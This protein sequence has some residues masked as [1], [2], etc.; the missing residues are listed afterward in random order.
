MTKSHTQRCASLVRYLAGTVGLALM[1]VSVL[2]AE[3][4]RFNLPA[5]DAAQSVKELARQSGL[6]V[7]APNADLRGVGTN[8]VDGDYEPMEALRLMLHGTGLDI[9]QTDADTVT[10]VRPR[11]GQIVAQASQA[12]ARPEETGPAVEATE[13][14]GDANVAQALPERLEEIVVTGSR[15]RRSG[16][17]TLESAIVTDAEQIGRRAYTNVIQALDDTPGF[18]SSGVNPIGTDQGTL[19][20]GQSFADFFGLGSQR[21]LTLVNSRRFVSSNS[22]SSTGNSASPG[23]QVDLNLIPVGLVERIETVAIGG[24]P[25]YGSD[26][27]SGTVNVILKDDFEGLQT[28]AQYGI[29]EQGDGEGYTIRALAGWNFAE[30]RGNFAI[31]A[32][33]NEQKGLVLSKR[34][35][36]RFTLPNLTGSPSANLVTEDLTL[37][38]MT[39]GGLPLNPMTFGNIVDGSGTPLQF[40]ADGQL[41][42][43]IT[44]DPLNGLIAA[45]FTDGGDGVRFADHRSLLSPTERSLVNAIGHFDL[46]SSVRI[47]GEAAYAN[48][49]GKELS[50][51][52][53]FAAPLLSGTAI[54]VSI[55]N[56][57]LS[58][59]VRDT[60]VA[61]GVVDSFFLARNFSDLLDRGGLA[62]NTVEMY[63]LVGGLEGDFT[64]FGEDAGWDVS[65]NYGRSR[66]ESTGT[67]INNDRF[68]LA[69]DA[70]TDGSDNVVCASGGSCVPF[71]L[72]GENAFSDEAADY[73][74]DPTL[75]ISQN[76]QYVATANLT[77]SLP[78]R[79]STESIDFNIGIEYRREEG[80]FRPDA[81]LQEGTSLLGLSL[82]SPFVGAQGDFDTNE[83]YGELSVPIISPE[84]NFALIKSMSIQGAARYVDNSI[85][86]GDPTWSAGG[87]IAP[88]FP[89]FLDGLM[90]RGVYTRSIRAPAVTE[91]FSGASS[92]RAGIN[93]PCDARFYQEGNN[94]E[95]R[96]ANCTAALQAL[97]V[98]SPEDFDSTTFVLS[99]VG[100]ISGNEN[101]ENEKAKSWSL[102]MVYQPE[103]VTSFRL[104]ADWSHIRLTGGIESLGIGTLIAS[105]YDSP[106][107]P[108][109]A[110]CASFSRL[111]ADEV[112]PGSDNPVRVTGDIANGYNSGYINSASLEFAGLI[113]AAEYSFE[114]A[115]LLPASGEMLL[116]AK[117]FNNR[118]YDF[119]TTPVSPVS[120]SVGSV[121]L[122]DWSGQL[123]VGYGRERFD[124]YLQA[125]YT[126]SAK[127]S[128][129]ATSEDIPDADNLVG[130]YWKFN[131]TLG[132]G[133][134]ERLKA[135]LAVNNVF[136]KEPSR[137]ALY[138]GSFGTYD[139]IG[140][141]YL[142]SLTG[143]F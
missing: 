123:N 73:V 81:L 125:L 86:G 35:G 118:R 48:S 29:S 16:Y 74:T 1:A 47:F 105:C 130:S 76:E 102:G 107:F 56:A 49:E 45:G 34:T 54:P 135:Q 137:A 87:R 68:L 104:A 121:G 33:Y 112:G 132:F 22:V 96:A 90:F 66:A 85:A 10:I 57:F 113:V 2:A 108:N 115:S 5:G 24:A 139:L 7:F 19:N 6:Q 50:E 46:T 88:R 131:A 101:L 67:F 13:D 55:D 3:V 89:G 27:I 39:E 9:A 93:D 17:D 58:S 51:V 65:F 83:V 31:G 32:E 64:L 97:G 117:A 15:L 91:L 8:A 14:D 53:A 111:S 60:L 75:A 41:V 82:V 12:D 21:T 26:A 52:A 78:F 25:I 62:T 84:Q 77:G 140:R 63:R 23:Q 43:L 100:T 36:D 94:P 119:Q 69:I 142:L 95:V 103:A 4:Q 136:D 72:F 124:V 59:E 120:S 98:A 30:G 18:V 99:P 134:T 106:D 114:L 79:L 71:N 80:E 143:E 116:S 138:S 40:A 129:L 133:V 110:A 109:S 126:G 70:V 122:P 61:N 11:G 42:P 44:G 38:S 92:T 141:R 28:S 128:L 37:T 127:V 20:A